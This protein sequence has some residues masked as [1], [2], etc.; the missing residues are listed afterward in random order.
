MALDFKRPEIAGPPT[1]GKA[2][3]KRDI[4][5]HSA[6]LNAADDKSSPSSSILIAK[7]IMPGSFSTTGSFRFLFAGTSIK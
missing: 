4:G 3:I 6:C 5:L 7:I 2:Q 1:A